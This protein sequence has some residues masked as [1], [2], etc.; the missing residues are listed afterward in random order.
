M[1]TRPDQ[2]EESA[3]YDPGDR[4]EV[5]VEKIVPRGLGLA[6]AEDL[7]VFVPLSAPGDR[8]EVRLEQ[9][10]GRTAFAEIERVIEP[11]P[12]R[13]VPPCK[14]F[15]T[16]GGCDLQQLPY[17]RQLAAKVEMIKDSLHRIGKIEIDDIPMIASPNPLHYRT[18]ALWHVDTRVG[19]MGYY[20][21]NSHDVVDIDH[22]P[23]LDPALDATLQRFRSELGEGRF[24]EEKAKVEAAV[25]SD[26]KVSIN[27]PDLPEA[28]EEIVVD[29][30]GERYHF[31]ARSFFQGNLP[32]VE[33]L[34]EAATG[35]ASGTHALDLYCGVGLFSLPL[36]RRFTT[37][38]G[39]E[40]NHQA[41]DYAK[42]NGA[43]AG[44]G[45]LTFYSESVGRFI[46]DRDVGG[47]DLVLLDPPR[48]GTEKNVIQRIIRLQP[49]NVSYV[50]CDPSIL[51]RD[52]RRF[53]DGGYSIDSITALD[54]FPQTH[55]VEAVA[56]LS[57]G[58]AEQLGSPPYEGGVA[59][60][61]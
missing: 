58:Q 1:P 3:R 20:K 46:F 54:L 8:L 37:V 29:V 32:L 43:E 21:R 9:V 17:E 61:W 35:G 55:H 31:D 27:A 41:V 25:G 19:M 59:E 39:V 53:L 34:I 33:S 24:W 44:A 51:A 50:S 12:E 16:C 30:A 5:T 26:G 7:T 13:G 47:A 57:I 10:K 23:I 28:V 36:A 22:C 2:K 52:M 15:G 48:A 14:Y 4:L 42:R 45:N 40:A 18:R 6:F 38:T 56:R 49:K 60:A 11:S